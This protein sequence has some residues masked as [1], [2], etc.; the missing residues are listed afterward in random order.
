MLRTSP[1]TALLDTTGSLVVADTALNGPL[2]ARLVVLVG[3]FE[4]PW[5]STVAE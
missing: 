1:G 3:C 5:N 4:W 2:L